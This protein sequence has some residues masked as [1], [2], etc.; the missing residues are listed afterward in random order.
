M[1]S[2]QIILMLAAAQVAIAMAPGPNTVL[3]AQ[4]AMHG[5]KYGFIVA[6]GVLPIGV[7]WAVFGLIGMGAL[8]SAFPKFETILHYACGT[9]LCWLGVKSV[10]RSFKEPSIDVSANRLSTSEVFWAGI[11]SNITN[12]KTI[13]YYATI[14]T[15]TG[16]FALSMTYQLIA[17]VMMPVISFLWHITLAM[18]VS[19]KSMQKFFGN[20]RHWL[21]RIAGLVMIGFGVRLLVAWA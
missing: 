8:S 20:A 18:L 12:P 1:A 10:H 2:L 21:D 3:V 7:F 13:A 5:R 19:H 11:L 6:V 17:V 15:A 4:S 16:A 9:Y 14:F